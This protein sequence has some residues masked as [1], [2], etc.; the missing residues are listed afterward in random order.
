MRKKLLYISVNN[1]FYPLSRA[2][3]GVLRP[4]TKFPERLDFFRK[5]V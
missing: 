3:E 2:G 5:I 1:L 4:A